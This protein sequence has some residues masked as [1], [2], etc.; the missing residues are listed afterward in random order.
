MTDAITKPVGPHPAITDEQARR[1][2]RYVAGRGVD[3]EDA[4]TLLEM[5]GLGG[6]KS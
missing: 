6:G 1:A 2:T 4:R 3:V 5:L